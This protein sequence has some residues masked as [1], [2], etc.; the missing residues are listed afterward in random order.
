M[1]YLKLFL[2]VFASTFSE[3]VVFVPKK[4]MQKT[5]FNAFKEVTLEVY[6]I[7][8]KNKTIISKIVTNA[9][10]VTDKDKEDL[11]R[12]LYTETLDNIFE[13]Y[14]IKQ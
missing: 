9:K 12:Y 11:D 5:L 2:D 13:Y 8:G 3:K 10:L 4:T 14:G 1:K 6:E 7:K